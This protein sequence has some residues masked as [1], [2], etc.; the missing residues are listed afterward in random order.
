MAPS[1]PGS[2]LCSNDMPVQVL[3][4]LGGRYLGTPGGWVM[5]NLVELSLKGYLNEI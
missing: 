4:A 2:H 1:R 5:G 3:K